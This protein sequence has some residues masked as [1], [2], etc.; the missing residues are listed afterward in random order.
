MQLQLDLDTTGTNNTPVRPNN[1]M[2]TSQTVAHAWMSYAKTNALK[3]KT[4][5]YMYAQHAFLS[6]VAGLLQEDMPTILSIC[7]ATGRSLESI[8]ERTQPR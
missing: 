8:I 1:V 7:L 6:G 4:R 3:P 5:A 2:S